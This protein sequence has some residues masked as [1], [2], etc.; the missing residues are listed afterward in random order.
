[1]GNRLKSK[2]FFRI[3]K[4][5]S[6]IIPTEI[7]TGN[8]LMTGSL[9]TVLPWAPISRQVIFMFFRPLWEESGWEA[10]CARSAWIEPSPPGC[11]HSIPISCTP[12][13]SFLAT[14]GQTFKR[15]GIHLPRPVFPHG[16]FYVVFFRASSWLCYC[17]NNWKASTTYRKWYIFNVKHWI[18]RSSLKF[19]E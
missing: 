16:Q 3:S 13:T 1:M 5:V 17:R 7:L 9:W 10:I 8:K 18:C 12:N 6:P 4:K 14:V 15:L 11:R 19:P 2:G